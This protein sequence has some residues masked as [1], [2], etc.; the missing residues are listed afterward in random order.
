MFEELCW[1]NTFIVDRS[2]R[3]NWG[4]RYFAE[5]VNPIPRALWPGKPLI[6]IDYAVARGFSS[7]DEAG[8]VT[9]TVSTGMIGQGVVNFGRILGPVFAALLMS[10]WAALLAGLDLRGEQI[11]R[12]PLYAL[13]LVLTYNMGRDITF[14]TLYTFMFGWALV[15]WLER[16]AAPRFSRPARGNPKTT[17][18]PSRSERRKTMRNF[19]KPIQP[20]PTMTSAVSPEAADKIEG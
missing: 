4:A 11:G 7:N 20:Q 13:G 15:W 6:G 1:I 5:I 16:R 8:G 10:L 19:R 9:A 17:N 3:P 14:I 2:Y 12:I 18:R